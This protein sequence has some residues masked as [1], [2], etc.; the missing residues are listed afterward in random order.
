MTDAPCPPARGA[1][2][3]AK[4]AGRGVLQAG[5]GEPQLASGAERPQTAPDGDPP[6]PRPAHGLR[7]RLLTSNMDSGRWRGSVVRAGQRAPASLL[8]SHQCRRPRGQPLPSVLSSDTGITFATGQSL[9]RTPA[10][11]P[12][13]TACGPPPPQGGYLSA[14]ELG[15]GA[16]PLLAPPTARVD[17]CWTNGY[18]RPVSR[19]TSPHS[20]A[21]SS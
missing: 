17:I 19:I 21:P 10:N 5:P 2:A 14:R 12:A 20:P 13:P 7:A 1:P 16:G 3:T 4:D 15:R 8:P 11:V 9:W 18:I 6:A